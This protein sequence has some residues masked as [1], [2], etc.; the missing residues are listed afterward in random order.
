MSEDNFDK[1]KKDGLPEDKDRGQATDDEGKTA[2]DAGNAT[3]NGNGDIASDEGASNDAVS[4]EN[5]S[6]DGNSDENAHEAEDNGDNGGDKIPSDPLQSPEIRKKPRTISLPTFVFSLVALVLAAVMATHTFTQS[7]YKK[8]LGE[9]SKGNVTQGSEKVEGTFDELELLRALF[10]TYS[11]Y[12]IDDEELISSV[13]KAYVEATGDIHAEY[14]TKEEYEAI[15]E[16][17]AGNSQGIGINVIYTTA[18]CEG[19]D[20]EVFKVINVEPD[21]PAKENGIMVG[22]LIVNVKIGDELVTVESLGYY[23]ALSELRGEEGTRAEFRVYRPDSTEK[24]ID[25][26]VERREIKTSSV[27]KRVCATD[28]DVGIVKI[29]EFNLTTPK[30]FSDAVEYLKGEGCTK[31]VFD[32]RYNGGGDLR[33]ISAVLSYFL[34]EGD[35][36]LSTEDRGGNIEVLKVAPVSYQGE[37]ADCSISTSDI[38]KFKGLDVAV[39]CNGR[40][41]SAAELFTATFRDYGMGSVVGTKTY[42]KGSMQSI[43]SL[44]LFGYDGA[45]KLTT[46]M[47]FP[48]CGEGYDGVG[49]TPDEGF[50][51]ELDEALATKNI[52]EITDAEDNQLQKAIES[53]KN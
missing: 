47:Y 21:S 53:L 51:V 2:Q 44:A 9:V 19:T 5:M 50:E 15:T 27:M 6:D 14:Y 37:A 32:V 49:I 34:D 40:T 25:F 39:L 26:S 45:L 8:K 41:A 36:I 28:P 17:S 48:P 24:W 1:D 30:Q 23:V 46:K 52:Y 43:M 12:D 20:Y 29:T 33:S 4:E 10:K 13:L 7:Y 22:D 3:D 11:Y 31:F 35:T 42:G 16:S 18:N 38:G